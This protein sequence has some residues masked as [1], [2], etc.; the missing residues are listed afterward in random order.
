MSN[1]QQASRRGA[2]MVLIAIL[3]VGFMASV[4]LSIDIAH[5]H[6]AKMELRIAT[7]AAA[8][9][10][11]EALAATQDIPTAIAQGKRLAQANQVFNRPLQL[12]DSDFQFGRSQ[13]NND[14]GAFN[15]RAGAQ[16]FNSVR[17]V[18]ARTDGSLSGPVPLFFSRFWGR[19]NLGMTASA[20]AT[21]LRRDVVLVVDRSGSMAGQKVNDLK[22]A[23]ITFGATLRSSPTEER[24]GL[25]SY[26]NAST[27]DAQLTQEISVVASAALRIVVGGA[28]NITSGIDAGINILN[29]RGER[30][31]TERVMILMTDGNHNVGPA[32]PSAAN[33]AA[34]QDII[35]HAITF[36]ADADQSAMRN[37]ARITGGKHFHANNGAQLA[38]IYREIALSLNTL[39]TE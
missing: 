25:A 22:G 19:E 34:R 12:R 4:A 33:R 10:T 35:I 13:L 24:I 6:L 31:F 14:G 28:T 15:F 7:D 37:V 32:P 23:L 27:Q 29:A 5:M 17:V 38:A 2:A 16:R 39:L 21:F 20:I 36:G 3:M 1:P 18:G 9:A 26:S 11:A 8:K 30:P